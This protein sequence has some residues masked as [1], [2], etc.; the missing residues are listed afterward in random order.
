MRQTGTLIRSQHRAKLL[1]CGL[2]LAGL[3]A[4][5]SALACPDAK[6][7]GPL[8]RVIASQSA[9]VSSVPVAMGGDV[10]LADCN[11]GVDGQVAA[12]PSA[13]VDVSG[14]AG[15]QTLVVQVAAQCD[16]LILVQDP[17]AEWHF[18]A[19]MP[20]PS[21]DLPQ[22]ADGEYA[23][24]VGAPGNTQCAA[25]LSIQLA[26]AAAPTPSAQTEFLSLNGEVLP[27]PGSLD[28]YRDGGGRGV[29]DFLVTGSALGVVEGTE[30]YSLESPLAASAVH[31]GL[32]HIGQTGVISVRFRRG[33]M[34]YEGSDRN[35]IL[36]Q[37]RG[38]SA[39]AYEF[40]FTFLP[41]VMLSRLFDDPL[42]LS[43]HR[44]LVGRT[45]SILVTGSADGMVWGD[46]IYTDDSTLGRAVVHAGLLD[47]GQSGTVFVSLLPGEAA[48]RGSTRNGVQS[49]TAGAWG[50][51]Y[52]LSLTPP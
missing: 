26:G 41:Q 5:A 10:R 27:D 13:R 39:D 12:A 44:D 11:L 49:A 46:D 36:S 22:A 50:G 6:L 32:L 2:I 40:D 17:S 34:R 23:I 9:T 48:Y 31:A 28:A 42:T 16:A 3:I 4:P 47:V 52:R 43:N 20:N 21:L 38:A 45:L 7:S 15:A 29:Q 1:G 35:G 24:W 37:S 30:T 8:L 25:T 33:A 14:S 51:S 18:S 19:S